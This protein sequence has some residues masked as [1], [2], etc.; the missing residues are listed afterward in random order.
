MGIGKWVLGIEKSGILKPESLLPPCLFAPAGF[1][2]ASLTSH[3]PL[4]PATRKAPF[5]QDLLIRVQ[6]PRISEFLLR[7]QTLLFFQPCPTSHR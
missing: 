6:T 2:Q 5:L 1:L 3:L 7:E 4:Q